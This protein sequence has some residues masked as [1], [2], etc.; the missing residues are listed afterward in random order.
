M[1]NGDQRLVRWETTTVPGS[2]VSEP[3]VYAVGLDVTEE[4]AILRRTLRAERLAAVGTLAAGLA[5]EVRNPLNSATLQLQVLRRRLDDATPNRTRST[6]SLS[7]SRRRSAASNGWSTSSS[8]SRDPDR[9]PAIHPSRRGVPGRPGVHP[10]GGGGGGRPPGRRAG[11]HSRCVSADPE[12]LRQVLQNLV[13]NAIEAMPEGACSRY[14]R[15]GGPGA[16]GRSSSR[17]KTPAG[18]QGRGADLRAFFT[19]KPS[20]TGSA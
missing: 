6:R 4:Q 20:G 18:L 15:A 7:W 8:R 10:P 5:H 12:R 9:S 14:A 11:P 16:P 17:S 3:M 1:K 19:T 13:R 2:A